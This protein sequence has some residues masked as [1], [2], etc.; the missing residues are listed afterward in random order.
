MLDSFLNP[1]EGQPVGAGQVLLVPTDA[2]PGT[3]Q[4]RGWCV[5]SAIG[6]SYRLGSEQLPAFLAA[7]RNRVLVCR[8][9]P[10]VFWSLSSQLRASGDQSAIG[11]LRRAV[12]EGRFVDV[13][14]W[15]RLIDLSQNGYGDQVTHPE[16]IGSPMTSLASRTVQ[17]E[18]ATRQALELGPPE[19]FS[20]AANWL[21]MTF[22]VRGAIALGQPLPLQ[23]AMS[24]VD[25]GSAIEELQRNQAELGNQ[26]ESRKDLRHCYR[27]SPGPIKL[28]NG[29]PDYD[30]PKLRTR[31]A[32]RWH[33]LHDAHE[34]PAPPAR[35]NNKVSLEPQDWGCLVD[36][37]VELELWA[38]FEQVCRTIEFLRGFE[39]IDVEYEVVPR[40]RPRNVALLGL[41]GHGWLRPRSGKTLV[42]VRFPDLESRCLAS[43]CQSR[44]LQSALA[45]AAGE[46]PN[47]NVYVADSLGLAARLFQASSQSNA[48]S[49]D[50]Q[51]VAAMLIRGAGLKLSDR[52]LQRLI[53]QASGIDVGLQQLRGVRNQLV[54][55]FGE[56]RALEYETP[57][58]IARSLE[59]R[60]GSWDSDA[61]LATH[62]FHRAIYTNQWRPFRW[63]LEP[64]G[65]TYST[66]VRLNEGEQGDPSLANYSEG[67]LSETRRT[68]SGRVRGRCH[69]S[70][71]TAEYL[72]LADDTLKAIMF[73]IASEQGF[74]GGCF[75]GNLL[76]EVPESDETEQIRRQIE[77]TTNLIGYRVLGMPLP[78]ETGTAVRW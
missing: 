74:A 54:E 5:G 67:L 34:Y 2:D 70:V 52:A 3:Q 68:S 16:D 21:A 62:R 49:P 44:F 58:L 63:L 69:L 35:R 18:Q 27:G 29:L 30:S 47:L 56:L 13:D 36:C 12:L 10:R 37:D 55:V 66:T 38:K 40:L 25:R 7:H 77:T 64:G 6:A 20:P 76:V 17:L 1:W 9:A 41:V 24:A 46:Q 42:E 4:R 45:R 8:D 33:D 11:I 15:Q 53:R 28:R 43:L 73:E 31:L 22:A 71:S 50:L 59:L 48:L 51:A 19:A 39:F 14:I 65:P 26:I 72:D 23:F 60:E 61:G 32:Q 57:N 78:C 75:G